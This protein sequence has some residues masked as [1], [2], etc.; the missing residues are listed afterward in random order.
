MSARGMELLGTVDGLSAF[1]NIVSGERSQLA[2]IY[3]NKTKLKR[4]L[5]PQ[6]RVVK[7]SS[8]PLDSRTLEKLRGEISGILANIAKIE[9]DNIKLD[10]S[11]GDY[12]F[13]S[14]MLTEYV[15][16]LNK[17]YAFDI[18]PTILFE[19]NNIDLLSRYLVT[20]Y[21]AELE[22]NMGQEG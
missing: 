6:K 3:G 12:G 17:K 15:N 4:F 10:K 18:N 2:V 7:L 8:E 19:Y 16:K 13:D 9:I 5:N 21:A 22:K 20:N 1:K 11:F 14:I